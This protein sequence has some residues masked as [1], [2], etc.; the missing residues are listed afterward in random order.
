[1]VNKPTTS[2]F[3]RAMLDGQV[4]IVIELGRAANLSGR[5]KNCCVD[6]KINRNLFPASGVSK[7]RHLGA[8]FFEHQ[9]RGLNAFRIGLVQIRMRM[10]RADEVDIGFRCNF[11]F[12]PHGPIH[13][14]YQQSP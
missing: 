6:K 12:E 13:G 10:V 8:S 2:D 11:V 4:Q 1:M 7:E 5:C 9:V 14:I 3:Y